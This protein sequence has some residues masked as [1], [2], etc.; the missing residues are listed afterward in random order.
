MTSNK[1]YI[2]KQKAWN[3][4]PL[5]FAERLR[6]RSILV[7][8]RLFNCLLLVLALSGSLSRGVE[9]DTKIEVVKY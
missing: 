3:L 9:G 6:K 5:V 7:R 2:L 8:I 1:K 4:S